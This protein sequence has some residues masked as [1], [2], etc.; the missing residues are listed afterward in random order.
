V[1]AGDVRGQLDEHGHLHGVFAVLGRGSATVGGARLT[2]ADGQLTKLPVR[3]SVGPGG[4]GTARSITR[5]LP[6]GRVDGVH[7]P[8][9][10]QLPARI[11]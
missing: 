7:E 2:K 11:D 1:P 3:R 10:E 6:D 9:A 8:L 4:R 5:H